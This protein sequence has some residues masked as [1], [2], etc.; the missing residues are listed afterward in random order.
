MMDPEWPAGSDEARRLLARAGAPT[1]GREERARIRAGLGARRR[2]SWAIWVGLGAAVASGAA[3]AAW[4]GRVPGRTASAPSPVMSPPAARRVEVAADDLAATALRRAL[5]ALTERRAAEAL[6]IAREELARTPPSPLTPELRLV[7]VR[8]LILDGRASEAL[9]LLESL[10]L[11]SYPR[12]DD[13]AVLRAELWAQS[14]NCR[15]AVGAR[16]E[17]LARPVEE[18]LAARLRALCGEER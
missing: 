13:L 3:M 10:P 9:A 7:E 5:R 15:R 1:L 18:A 8:A 16:D 12:A 11:D 14:G 17:L 2:R 4:L 6:D